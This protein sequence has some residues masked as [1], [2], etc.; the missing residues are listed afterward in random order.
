MRPEI[1]KA[2]DQ[3]LR[4]F[5]A[6]RLF[7]LIRIV[8]KNP[9]YFYSTLCKAKIPSLSLWSFFFFFIVIS[10]VNAGFS[11]QPRDQE[12]TDWASQ[13]PLP[14][15]FYVEKICY[16]SFNREHRNLKMKRCRDFIQMLFATLLYFPIVLS[17]LEPVS[18]GLLFFSSPRPLPY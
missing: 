5:L 13:A 8:K 6:W 12:L 7:L 2:I 15:S 10:T 9:L 4:C 1:T 17:I 18:L 16:F 14:W 11:L 3:G